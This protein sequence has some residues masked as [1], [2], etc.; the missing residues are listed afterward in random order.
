VHARGKDHAIIGLVPTGKY[1]RLGE[2]PTTYMYFAEAQHWNSGMTLHVRTAGDPDAFVP[3]LRAEV[4]AI[5]PALPL[6]NVRS[7]ESHLGIALLPA[8]LSGA[9][10]G[11]FG[12]LGLA[13]A[14]VGIY[15][16]MAYS[17]SQRKREIGIRMAI[18]AASGDVVRLVMRQGLTLV[19][20]GT[21]L[22]LAGALAVSRLIRGVL[23]GN[24]A[25]DPL[26]FVAV[27]LLLV[28]VA[29]LATWLPARKA[30]ALD[31]LLALRQ[32]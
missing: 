30:S 26:T 21:G 27:P 15:G 29:M 22:G 11:I 14:A 10:L 2:D 28:G 5:D 20:V 16:V 9:V 7:M 25:N 13:L 24:G 1:Q 17:V 8:R 19:L 12:I 23:Y 32:E 31:P 6:S 3:V 4:A 18:G